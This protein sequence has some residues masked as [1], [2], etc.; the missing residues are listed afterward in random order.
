MS[1][2]HP[3]TSA[4]SGKPA[5][6]NKPYPEFPLT[7]HPS[8]SWCKKIRGKLHYFGPWD[9]PDGTLDKYNQQKDAL[10]A[11]RKPREETDGLTVKQLVNKFLN[12]KL[13]LRDNGE[14]SALMY[15]DYKGACDCLIDQFGKS[16]L[17]ADLD[18][19]DFAALRN[20]M[21]KQW[22][23][24][25]LAKTIACIRSVFKFGYDAGLIDRPI[26]FG[27]GFK[28]P[29]KKTMRLHRTSKGR[30]CSRRRKSAS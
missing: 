2:D 10:H 24:H 19:D 28:R 3:T 7:P 11:G 25:R 13:T 15:I 18:P 4:A 1:K 27:P 26:R 14:L 21:A 6:P 23:F 16:R 17:V 22:G 5:K 9:D 30:S 29:S 20:K 8:G 12:A